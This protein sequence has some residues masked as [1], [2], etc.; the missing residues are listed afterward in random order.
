MSAI[1]ACHYI[2]LKLPFLIL[3]IRYPV[4]AG[5]NF[6]WV[7][8]I[9]NSLYVALLEDFFLSTVCYPT[10]SYREGLLYGVLVMSVALVL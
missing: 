6:Y 7:V 9:M 8:L 5:F 10:V 4:V 2:S 1:L 3:N